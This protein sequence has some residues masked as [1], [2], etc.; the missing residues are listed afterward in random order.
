MKDGAGEVEN[1]TFGIYSVCV[2]RRNHHVCE[3][4]QV[5]SGRNAKSVDDRRLEKLLRKTSK[6]IYKLR[7]SKAGKGRP[8]V[9]SFK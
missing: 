3:R 2:P 6:E 8:D 7:K 9:I 5:E 4:L 1:P